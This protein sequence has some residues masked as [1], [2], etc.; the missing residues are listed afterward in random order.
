LDEE[1]QLFLAASVRICERRFAYYA[2]VEEVTGADVARELGWDDAGAG[3]LFDIVQRLADL[4]CLQSQAYLGGRIDLSPR[5]VGVV[6]ASE[7]E[8]TEWQALVDELLPEWE[9]V[10]VEFKRSVQLGRDKEKAEFVRDILALATTKAS[11]RRL[12]IIGFDAKSHLFA[13]SVDPGI[14]QDRVERILYAYA[15]PTPDLRYRT[16]V[17][18]DGEIGIMEVFRDAAK[19]PYRVKKSLAHIN[20]G[21]VFVRHGSQ[22]EPPTP[23]ELEDLEAEGKAAALR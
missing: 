2:T 20:K 9:T 16:A 19:I 10:T 3:R 12:Y 8:Q 1:Q 11:G 17:W 22:V 18:E 23:A 4:G 5:Y 21:D 7:A 6:R 13:E 14:D 15:E